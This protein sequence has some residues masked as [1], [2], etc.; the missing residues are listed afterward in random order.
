LADEAGLT[1]IVAGRSRA[2]AEGFC[3]SLVSEATLIPANFDRNG[4][5]A[6]QV[7]DFAPDIVVDAS[8]PFQAY[9][10]AP[11]RL[12]EAAIA[13]GANYI[14]LADGSD[15]VAGITAFDAAARQRGTYVIAGA[16]SF[17]VLTAA[18]CR[19][20]AAGLVTVERI[21]GG[22]A[23]SPY[24]GVGENVIRAISSYAG[25]RIE[26]TREG[27]DSCGY[28]LTETKRYTIAPPG[29]LP[30]W[31][32][33]FSLVDVPDLK[34]LPPEW[35]GLKSIWMGA[36]PVPE[37]LH[38]GLVALAWVVRLRLL[39]SLVFL[40][41]VFHRAINT[42]RWGEHRGGMF[43]EIDGTTPDG[44]AVTRSWHLLAEGDDG[45]FIPSMAVEAIVRKSLAGQTP[46]PGARAAVRDLELED[47][48]AL[49][50]RRTISTGFRGMEAGE[51]EGPL[52]RRMLGEAWHQLPEEVRSM[53]DFENRQI[54][55]GMAVVENG[56]N[57]LTRWISWIFGLP[58]EG[59]DVPVTVTFEKKNGSERWTRR[60]AGQEFA[61]THSRGEGRNNRLLVERFGPFAFAIALVQEGERLEF[62]IRR[63][64]FL[65][66]PLP[67][68]LAPS[69]DTYE[70]VR[71][72][73]FTF[74]VEIRLPLVGRLVRYRGW[75][76][77]KSD[78]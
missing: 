39:P 67:T 37:V 28:G 66:I 15:F 50:S 53:H 11:Y 10:A 78:G 20:L 41:P 52:F 1:L 75:L 32:K 3:N 35:P 64:S 60:F 70:T 77:R 38:R 30:L 57:V 13:A 71:D 40:A 43:I 44:Q 45:P 33:L 59:R 72:G 17:P 7:L 22:I 4:D 55:E 6:T 61:S 24:A 26:L 58:R 49:F 62:R 14:D 74:D 23:P 42:L 56:D 16:S 5:V 18:V 36:G 25:K 63:W 19:K 68:A 51:A 27:R 47:Y 31:N 46:E 65:S 12:V 54:A 73:R 9:G 69:G 76:V 2:K 8:G 48:D 29:R 34:V 21:T